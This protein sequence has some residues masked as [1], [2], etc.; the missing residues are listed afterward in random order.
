MALFVDT[1][2]WYAAVDSG[3][4]ANARA[5]I[6]LATGERLHTTDHVLIETWSLLDVR[7]GS[8]VAEEFLLRLRTA[9]VE[10]ELI[11]PEDLEAAWTIGQK[12]SDQD[13]SIV[14]RTSFA[15]M[16]RLRFTRVVFFDAHFAT[17]RYGLR[18]DKAF[19]VLR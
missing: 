16:E 5:K 15:V 10:I 18:R 3:D 19:E 12:F 17:F 6:L 14:D 2:A 9:K 4:S 11:E 7:F 13:F 8:R 1:W